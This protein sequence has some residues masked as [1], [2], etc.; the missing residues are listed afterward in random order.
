MCKLAPNVHVHSYASKD[1]LLPVVLHS[2]GYSLSIDIV[3]IL[4]GFVCLL[5]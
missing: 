4:H 5:D 1:K 3:L 2:N